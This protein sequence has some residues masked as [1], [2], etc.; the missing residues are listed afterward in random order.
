MEITRK[1]AGFISKITFNDSSSFD[2]NENDIVIFVGPNNVGK[3]QALKDIY[4]LSA[5]PANCVVV[6]SIEISEVLKTEMEFF[7]K[8]I[9]TRAQNGFSY[10]G[11]GYI[12]NDNGISIAKHSQVWGC[13]RNVFVSFL[14]TEDRL[15]IC[16]PPNSIDRND[17]AKHPIHIIA[18]DPYCRKRISSY[19]KKAFG[20]DILPFTTN[21][22]TVPLS[23]TDRLT[24][25]YDASCGDEFSH[26]EKISSQLDK[27]PQV[28]EQG[29]GIRSF[30]GILLHLIIDHRKV[31]LIDEPESFLHPPQARIIGHTIGEMLSGDQQAFIATHSQEIITG[32]LE[33]CPERV[34]IIRITREENINHFSVLKH[35][36]FAN[37]WTDPLLRHSNIMAGIFHKNVVLCESDSDCRLYSVIHSYMR[38]QEG[39]YSETLFIHC[40][41]KQRM[42]KVAAAL[43]SLDIP[44]WII[45]DIDIL[46]DPKILQELIESVGGDWSNFEANL[47]ILRGNLTTNKSFVKRADFK[48]DVQ[49]ILSANNDPNLIDTE[50]KSIKSLLK[51]ETQ[52]GMLKRG[53]KAAVPQGKAYKAYEDIDTELRKLKIYIVPVGELECFIKSVGSHGPDWVNEV[54]EQY[55][56]LSDPV[57]DTLKDFIRSWN[58]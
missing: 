2:V 1:C 57:Y 52:W 44:L 46:N 35:D 11:F 12:I 34:K 22:K 39:R 13:F 7:M 10:E 6:S 4:S 42:K 27:C 55:P 21:G 51:T 29:D 24:T 8:A 18:R 25:D 3:S 23:I 43:R 45:P 28:H 30:T 54:L 26:I 5:A 37:L 32:L 56:D 33:V 20:K 9:S 49:N 31:F 50:I 41:G 16:N 19:F 15:S 38:E 36:D 47:R 48:R 17:S 14:G 58:L 40:G 53:G